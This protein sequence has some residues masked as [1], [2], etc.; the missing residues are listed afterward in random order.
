MPWR[1]IH[2][3]ASR[4]STRSFYAL[5]SCGYCS[6]DLGSHEMM[7]VENNFIQIADG[8]GRKQKQEGQA[9]I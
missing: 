5:F 9:E 6:S 4:N 3:S 2:K 7:D 1:R 8:P